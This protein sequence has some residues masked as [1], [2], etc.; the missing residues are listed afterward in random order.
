[1]VEKR[2]PRCE[3][4]KPMNEY[5]SAK[6]GRKPIYCK[7]CLRSI[8]REPK[9]RLSHQKCMA[10][11][12]G[13]EWHLTLEEFCEIIKQPC[14][15]CHGPLPKTGSGIDRASL[16]IGYTVANSI[17][18]CAICNWVRYKIFQPAEML[19][20]GRAIAD[21]RKCRGLGP[22]DE[23]KTANQSR[24]TRNKYKDRKPK[25]NTNDQVYS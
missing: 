8:F 25:A 12:R 18:C 2:C 22:N 10:K 16:E 6:G 5:Y 3:K 14:H 20:I 7:A 21:V 24:T 23:L 19:I 17:P 13:I 15:Y 9:S 4:T 11:R 1:M